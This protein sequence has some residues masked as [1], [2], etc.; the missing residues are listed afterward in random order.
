MKN[1]QKDFEKKGYVIVKPERK[2]LN[3]IRKNI[4]L[5][6]KKKI[7]SKYKNKEI[8]SFFNTFHR[9]VKSKDLNEIRFSTYNLINRNK[10]FQNLYY[11]AAKPFLNILVGN[12]LAMQKK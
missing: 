7:N 3:E 2:I 9:F 6:I 4:Y 1:I 8:D 11:E 10:K 5:S 12:E